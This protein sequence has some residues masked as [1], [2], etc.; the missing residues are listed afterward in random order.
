[1]GPS[2][3]QFM[4]ITSQKAFFILLTG[5]VAL[6][7]TASIW[8]SVVIQ[9]QQAS[10]N[11]LVELATEQTVLIQ[12][13]SKLSLL[14]KLQPN[15][16]RYWNELFEAEQIWSETHRN[17]LSHHSNWSW[18]YESHPEF[19]ESTDQL[20]QYQYQISSAI[21]SL[22][23]EFDQEK[24]SESID[25]IIEQEEEYSG[26]TEIL[27][28]QLKQAAEQRLLR[29]QQFF[30]LTLCFTILLIMLGYHPVARTVAR[31]YE[32]QI[33]QLQLSVLEKDELNDQM[34]SMEMR[35][36]HSINIQKAITE[37][38]REAK[39]YAEQVSVAKGTFLSTMSHEIR[40]PLNS[41]IGLTHLLMD[42]QPLPRQ[43]NN[44]EALMFSAKNLKSLINNILDLS[45]IE[46]GRYE[47]ELEPFNIHEV[48]QG[49]YYSLKVQAEEKELQFSLDL[50][51]RIPQFIRGDEIRLS[52]ILN[53]LVSNAIK[54]TLAGTVHLR[55]ICNDLT[56]DKIEIHFEV[57]DSGIGIPADKLKDIFNEYTQAES[58]TTRIFGGTGLGLA[59]TEKLVRLHNSQIHVSSQP[60]QGSTFSFVISYDL[61]DFAD[62]HL[63]PKNT[64]DDTDALSGLTVLFAE[65]NK[66]NIIV[67]RQFLKKWGVTFD[68]AENGHQAVTLATQNRYDVIL[69]DLN[70]PVVDGLTAAKKIREASVT[71]PMVALSAATYT[72]IEERLQ[73]AGIEDFSPKP[74]VPESLFQT[75]VKYRGKYTQTS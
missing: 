32:Q 65:D 10:Q 14:I 24:F 43:V 48:V 52:Q 30:Y 38:L 13:I 33:Q 74:F 53:N 59:I 69:M 11:R 62:D 39:N 75:L 40:T 15:T 58:N 22:F 2:F 54:F 34:N 72:E 56:E 6:L 18:F 73:Q 35:L 17:A 55:V 3:I 42:D 26:L 31:R 12:K 61:I 45:K 49:V 70:M 57:A 8:L 7:I 5:A 28:Y 1:M 9:S 21:S 37:N 4:L 16:D 36:H 51:P 71:T 60:H 50:D 20:S 19:I 44:L 41:I 64:P 23:L 29:Y 47:L 46:A 27:Y 25:L 67:L 63:E 68:E 66:L